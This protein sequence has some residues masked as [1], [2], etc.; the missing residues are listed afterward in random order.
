M[1]YELAC[2]RHNHILFY[3]SADPPSLQYTVTA[4][5]YP[6]ILRKHGCSYSVIGSRISWSLNPIYSESFSQQCVILS[7]YIYIVKNFNMVESETDLGKLTP[8]SQIPTSSF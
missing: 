4:S 2:H 3:E 7:V 6:I 1:Q 5:R 8:S